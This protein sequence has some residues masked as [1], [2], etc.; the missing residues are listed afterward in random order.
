MLIV[1]YNETY[2]FLGSLGIMHKSLY[3]NVLL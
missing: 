3:A 1:R 2:K